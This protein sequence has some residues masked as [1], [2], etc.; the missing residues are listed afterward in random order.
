MRE[1]QEASANDTV[2]TLQ[3]L[4]EFLTAAKRTSIEDIGPDHPLC[5]EYTVD[6]VG[7]GTRGKLKRGQADEGN[8][9]ETPEVHRIKTKAVCKIKAVD[10]LAKLQGWYAPK[11]VEIEGGLN[12]TVTDAVDAALEGMDDDE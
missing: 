12:V 2:M 1:L 6:Q 4:K 8:E 3:E 11:K 5:Q 9:V 10:M 7:G